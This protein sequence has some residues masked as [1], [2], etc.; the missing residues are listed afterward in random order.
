MRSNS[1]DTEFMIRISAS[2]WLSCCS[3]ILLYIV[4][5]NPSDNPLDVFTAE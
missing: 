1:G 5:P 3:G 4:Q 2:G